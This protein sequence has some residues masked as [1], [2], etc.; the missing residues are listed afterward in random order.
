MRCVSNCQVGKKVLL[1]ITKRNYSFFNQFSVPYIE[2]NICLNQESLAILSFSFFFISNTSEYSPP[3]IKNKINNE[4]LVLLS[5]DKTKMLTSFGI[6]LL[7]HSDLG[8]IVFIPTHAKCTDSFDSLSSSV[9]S[10]LN[11]IQCLD[12]ANFKLFFH[13]LLTLKN[14][15]KKH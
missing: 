5:S 15:V 4:T 13:S 12:T 3:I 2:L 14:Y 11:G 8:Y 9:Q 6:S 1:E 10:P 7:E